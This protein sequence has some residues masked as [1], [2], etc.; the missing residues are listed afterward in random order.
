MDPL[1]VI[2]RLGP[3]IGY[4]HAK[5]VRYHDTELALQGLLDSRW[6]GDPA[7]IPWDF[8]AVGHGA[9]E[10]DWWASFRSALD[11]NSNAR[12]MSVEHEDRLIPPEVGIAASAKLLA[13]AVAAQ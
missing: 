5:D 2:E 11:A 12:F 8:A 7:L 3:M 6:P 4:A 1:K 10:Q 9:H 13:G